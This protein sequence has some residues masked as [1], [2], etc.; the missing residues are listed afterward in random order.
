MPISDLLAQISGDAHSST[1][2]DTPPMKRKADSELSRGDGKA[3]R[4]DGASRNL[5][6]SATGFKA[7]DVLSSKPASKS[8]SKVPASVMTESASPGLNGTS[9]QTTS[10][11]VSAKPPKKGSYAEIMARGKAAQSNLGQIGKIQ[12]K[13]IEKAPSRRER[14]E[15]KDPKMPPSRGA[16]GGVRPGGHR[17]IREGHIE[18]RQDNGKSAAKI[19]TEKDLA[20][21]KTKKSAT[22]TT[23]YTGT[24]RPNPTAI[25]SSFKSTSRQDYRSRADRDRSSLGPSRRYT[26]ASE[27]EEEEDVE[28]SFESEASSDM[29]A[30]TFEVDE[31]EERAA[32]IARREDAEALQEENKLKREKEEKRRR[33]VAMAKSRR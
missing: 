1:P 26:Y 6:R 20:D 9:Q 22:A 21:K 3:F 23:G 17:H 30:A 32:R 28:D 33:L 18:A 24:A 29:E 27:E 8:P 10:G 2:M 15:R 16:N 13:R 11:T 31:E 19:A 7:H 5:L 12:H 4:R 25:R 14:Q